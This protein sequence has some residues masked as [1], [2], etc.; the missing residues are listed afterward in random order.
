MNFGVVLILSEPI[1]A[2]WT[3]SSQLDFYTVSIAGEGTN[4]LCLF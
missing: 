3:F 2:D 1:E 4:V